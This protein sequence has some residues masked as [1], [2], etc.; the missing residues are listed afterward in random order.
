[1][2]LG[3]HLNQHV[4]WYLARASG[5]VSW[6]LVSTSVLWGLVVS[7]RLTK[8]RP[9]AAWN[10]DLHRFLGALAVI[11]TGLH[12][13]GLALDRYVHFG[14]AE[15]LVPFVSKWRPGAVA[16]GI[17]G[18]YVLMAVELTSLMMRHLPRRLW[19]SIHASSFA[20]WTLATVHGLL[21][22]SDTGKAPV[23]LGG[24][25]VVGI[26]AGLTTLRLIIPAWRR[27]RRAARQVPGRPRLP[28]RP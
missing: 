24:L 10:L 14:P 22:G 9:P 23:R 25:V 16:W 12:L 1:M 20:L 15:L 21:S 5:L 26:G 13:L 17:V 2:H 6:L 18:L 19:R 4:W 8:K 11:F 28:A 27:R 7:G 3:G